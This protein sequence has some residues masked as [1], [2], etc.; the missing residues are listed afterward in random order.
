MSAAAE[1]S[2]GEPVNEEPDIYDFTD[3]SGYTIDDLEPAYD[4]IGD[5]YWADGENDNIIIEK[6][7]W[8]QVE[9]ILEED[10][11]TEEQTEE[12]SSGWKSK[13]G[14]YL[15]DHDKAYA[16][17][18]LVG[19][20]SG[21]LSGALGYSTAADVL[22]TGGLYSFAWGLGGLGASYIQNALGGEDEDV[23]EESSDH[24]LDEYSG[25]DVEVLDMES[26]GEAVEEHREE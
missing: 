5:S 14:S 24:E 22:F 25:W 17:G 19:M 4:T 6:S 1:A 15:F 2:E 21:L 9:E 12:E 10:E 16:K 13:I 18:G 20:G 11:E 23:S 3:G 26:Y 7:S 8:N